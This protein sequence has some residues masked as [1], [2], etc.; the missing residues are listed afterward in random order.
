MTFIQLNT[1]MSHSEL[2]NEVKEKLNLTA[3]NISYHSWLE[4]DEGDACDPQYIT[5]D[6]EVAVFVEM[7]RT[8]EEVNLCVTSSR[9][10]HRVQMEIGETHPQITTGTA[11]ER[12]AGEGD[13]EHDEHWHEF[14]MSETPMTLPI[15]WTPAVKANDKR[16]QNTILRKGT[17][18]NIREGDRSTRPISHLTTSVSKK[19]KA[20]ASPKD[21]ASDSD[22][23]INTQMIPTEKRSLVPIRRRLF[24]D[25]DG[26]EESD[27]YS[28][29]DEIEENVDGEGTSTLTTYGKFEESLHAML[30]D[31]GNDPVLFARD[32]P[33]VFDMGET[34]GKWKL[35]MQVYPLAHHAACA[36]H[37]FR[38]VRA[39]YQPKR[40]ANIVKDAA[41][42]CTM[43]EFNKKF[44][45]IQG[46]NPRCAS[47]LVDISECKYKIK[48]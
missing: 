3:S 20:P 30:I 44:I 48:F 11:V 35:V 8:I 14:A 5:D 32:A 2:V 24:H 6:Q 15:I 27:S 34:D 1:R 33:P 7:R 36:V 39:S 47:Y 29:E 42:A 21:T 16:P 25:S 23:A 19:G 9:L 41:R 37:L 10:V 28:G 43:N 38:N 18:I 26:E 12:V 4:I 13:S 46:L 17:G 45:E 40:L 31:N 22:E